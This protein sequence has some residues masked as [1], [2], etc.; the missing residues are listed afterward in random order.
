MVSVWAF[1]LWCSEKYF[2]FE[3]YL[4]LP[5]ATFPHNYVVR[6]TVIT[7]PERYLSMTL[8]L[9]FSDLNSCTVGCRFLVYASSSIPFVM[10]FICACWVATFHCILWQQLPLLIC[11]I[12]SSWNF[13]PVQFQVSF[14]MLV[15]LLL[16][17]ECC[18]CLCF[19]L[20]HRLRTWTQLNL[21]DK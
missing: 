14:P 10:Y 8:I 13:I 3:S 6:R 12:T 20:F 17:S 1:H 4:S 15:R 7:T 5:H 19:L 21:L 16:A 18:K 9:S 11:C 2:N